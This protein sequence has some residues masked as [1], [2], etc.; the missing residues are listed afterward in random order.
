MHSLRPHPIIALALCHSL[1]SRI[2]SC[3]KVDQNLL[4]FVTFF[5]AAAMQP[6]DIISSIAADSLHNSAHISTL[7][8]RK[9]S[10]FHAAKPRTA[11]PPF[12]TAN[13]DPNFEL[14]ASP[15]PAA[16]VG[17][18]RVGHADSSTVTYWDSGD[19]LST[20]RAMGRFGRDAIVRRPPSCSAAKHS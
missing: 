16:S 20:P 14:L 8:L 7:Y 15:P 5:S 9:F 11:G 17:R 6:T 2:R 4:N 13:P 1:D 3:T 18:Y 12:R 19:A 10:G